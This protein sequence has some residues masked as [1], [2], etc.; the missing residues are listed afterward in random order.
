MSQNFEVLRAWLAN[1]LA[2]QDD[3]FAGA[4]GTS[5]KE[6]E[7]DAAARTVTPTVLALAP[8]EIGKVVRYVRE[9]R[10]WTRKDLADLADID[11]IDIVHIETQSSFDPAPRMIVNLANVCG[12]STQR[13][14]I[15]AKHVYQSSSTSGPGIEMRFAAKSN[16]VGSVSSDELEAIRAL[17]S[18]LSDKA[19]DGQ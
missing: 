3:S 2:T 13:L 8:T 17:V 9:E 15:L 14:Q 5:L 1:R 18:V 19:V 7:K 12:F 16:S 4:G 6:L 11:E 10:G